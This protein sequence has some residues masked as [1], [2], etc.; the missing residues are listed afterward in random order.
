MPLAHC[1][2]SETI[3]NEN[4]TL[5]KLC[6]SCFRMRRCTP[7]A[8]RKRT[9]TSSPRFREGFVDPDRISTVRAINTM[10]DNEKL[11]QAVEELPFIYVLD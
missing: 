11:I 1:T 9:E 7:Y 4:E 2:E 6:L 10:D 3:A 5:G 8:E